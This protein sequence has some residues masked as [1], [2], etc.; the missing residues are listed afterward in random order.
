MMESK[1]NFT[2]NN[3]IEL[4]L[5]NVENYFLKKYFVLMV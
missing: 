4:L 5:N 3:R 1:V 2:K